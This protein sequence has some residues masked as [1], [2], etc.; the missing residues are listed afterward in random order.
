MDTVMLSGAWVIDDRR[1]VHAAVGVVLDG[2]LL[3]EAGAIHD[4]EPGGL[5]A[6]GLD[7]R[8]RQ[9][10]GAAPIVDLSLF[11]G[12]TWA[13]TTAPGTDSLT[14]YF[15]TD[16]RLGVRAGWFAPGGT[17]PYVAA[18]VFGG[19]VQWEL[20]GDDVVGT[21]IHHY[22]FA[23]GAAGRVGPVGVFAEWAGLGEQALSAGVSTAW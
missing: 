18:R 21:D 8:V 4:M 12:A 22:Q 3:T 7:Y 9:G 16:A 19:P 6:V 13:K 5:V 17:F 15:A 14:S 23:L 2:S 11:V 1:T 20:N 10:D